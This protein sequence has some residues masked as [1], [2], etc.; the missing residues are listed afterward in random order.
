[1]TIIP[2]SQLEGA[3]LVVDAVY[4]GSDSG[5]LADDP[6][7]QLLKG[8]NAGNFRY[9]GSITDLRYLIVCT[10]KEDSD[11]QDILDLESGTF[12]FYGDRR[13]P[14]HDLHDTPKNQNVILRNIFNCL[15]Q[16]PNSR[17]GIPPMFLFSK[18]PTP[19][20]P[21]SV[22]FR[23]VCAPGAPHLKGEGALISV[24]RITDSQRFRNYQATFTI[25]DIPVVSRRWIGALESG[26]TDANSAP[27]VWNMWLKSGL[28]R[29][30][31]AKHTSHVRSVAE[32]LP[33]ED[34]KKALLFKLYRYFNSTP[35]RFEYFAA[36]IFRMSDPRV[37]A[38]GVIRNPVD[39]GYEAFGRYILGLAA[40][41][42][43]VGFTLEGKCYNP[44]FGQ[45]KRKSVGVKETF[46]LISRLKNRQ[47]GVLVTTSVIAEQAYQ[48]ARAGKYPVIFLCG[49]D[50]V[51]IL[52]ERGISTVKA[53]EE[54]LSENY[55]A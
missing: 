17:M 4:E 13:T 45:R 38:E 20:S 10:L 35:G 31:Q 44:G 24:W 18:H 52:Y 19:N 5:N 36:D 41:P 25:L 39:G 26:E 50:I 51:S 28:Y 9:C 48:E 46:R 27:V 11:W 1:V 29:P 40:D 12:T 21:R 16:R 23:G 30:L 42:I 37:I 3:D 43:Y 6:I 15:H 54:W 32:Q 47:I 14:G 8:G 7:A 33:L 22:Q 53:L 34:S 55:P 49:S 2:F